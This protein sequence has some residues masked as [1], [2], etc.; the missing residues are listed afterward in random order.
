MS[1]DLFCSCIPRID[2]PTPFDTIESGM[3]WKAL[4]AMH[5][6]EFTHIHTLKIRINTKLKVILSLDIRSLLVKYPT[7]STL[8]IQI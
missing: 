2:R 5:S 7:F 3:E 1:H 4:H 8:T 6:M